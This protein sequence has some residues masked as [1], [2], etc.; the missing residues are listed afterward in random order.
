MQKWVLGTKSK[1]IKEDNF[2]CKR[3]NLLTFLLHAFDFVFISALLF[4][5][6][7][8]SYAIHSELHCA[9]TY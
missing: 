7:Y 1:I 8:I 3:L 9:E 4:L 2:K 5:L 6:A